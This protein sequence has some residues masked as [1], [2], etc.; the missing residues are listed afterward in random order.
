LIAAL[1]AALQNGGTAP[2]RQDAGLR[3]VP[4]S[5]PDAALLQLQSEAIALAL[6]VLGQ[7]P[8]KAPVK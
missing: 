6:Q 2:V 4:Y 3:P 7:A 5:G 1:A 8:P